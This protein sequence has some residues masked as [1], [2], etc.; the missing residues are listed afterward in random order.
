[1]PAVARYN[2]EYLVERFVVDYY[3]ER[4]QKSWDATGLR[5]FVRRNRMLP[6]AQGRAASAVLDRV[7]RF[8]KWIREVS[9]S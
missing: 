2:G 7:D 8:A 4:P 5:L 9:K 1:M 3:I 6:M